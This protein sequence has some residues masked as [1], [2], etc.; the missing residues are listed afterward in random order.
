MDEYLLFVAKILLDVDIV[1]LNYIIVGLYFKNENNLEDKS[2]SEDL[3]KF[4]EKNKFKLVL[5]DPF[6]KKFLD[7]KKNFI[8][9]IKV[10][11]KNMNLLE[12]EEIQPFEENINS[13]NNNFL[14]RKTKRQLEE[15]LIELTKKA[16]YLY[17]NEKKLTLHPIMIFVDQIKKEFNLNKLQYAGSCKLENS[18]KL[19][20]PKE[21]YMLVFYKKNYD[22]FEGLERFYALT[23]NKKKFFAY[24]F[25]TKKNL[26]FDFIFLY[27]NLF[28]TNKKYYI[29]KMEK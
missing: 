5:Y 9:E 18:C 11:D 10:P 20:V 21:G 8:N 27:F 7:D 29:F 23:Q 12:E 25:Q 3:I 17:I 16:N 6:E 28:D 19:R 15:E 22:E 1:Q 2:Y 14:K 4:C 24:D 13:Q 26:K